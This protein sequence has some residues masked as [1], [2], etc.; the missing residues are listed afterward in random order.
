MEIQWFTLPFV[1][2]PDACNAFGPMHSF[3]VTQRSPD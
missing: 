3:T 1:V 2:N